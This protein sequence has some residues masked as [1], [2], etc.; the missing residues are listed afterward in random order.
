MEPP[1]VAHH[2]RG[3]GEEKE[4]TEEATAGTVDTELAGT[5][6]NLGAG[7]TEGGGGGAGV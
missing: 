1:I 3:S 7:T 4:E 2:H 6:G 5:E